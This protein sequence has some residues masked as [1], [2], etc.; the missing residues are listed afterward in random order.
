MS[1]RIASTPEKLLHYLIL[2]HTCGYTTQ[3]LSR[4]DLGHK[5]QESVLCSLP[6]NIYMKPLGE[7]ICQRRVMYHQFANNTHLPVY[8]YATQA[9]PSRFFSRSCRLWRSGWGR[10]GFS[11]IPDSSVSLGFRT[12]LDLR[13]SHFFTM[14]SDRVNAVW[15]PFC[16]QSC[17]STSKWQL[18]TVSLHAIS[19]CIQTATVPHA[20]NTS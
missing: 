14:D 7:V 17:C 1:E 15:E 18:C 4:S 11:S 16:V 13:I 6:F 5:T 8:A 9:M 10:M 2:N 19:S 20:L 3:Q 12:L